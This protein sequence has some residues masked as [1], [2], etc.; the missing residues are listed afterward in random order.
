VDYVTNLLPVVLVVLGAL[1]ASL[2]AIA[3]L[4]ASKRDDDALVFLQKIMDVVGRLVGA[5][6]VKK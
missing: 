1:I 6:V 5:N 2:A 3:P 4:T